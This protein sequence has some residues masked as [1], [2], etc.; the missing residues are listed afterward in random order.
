MSYQNILITPVGNAEDQASMAFNRAHRRTRE[1]IERAFGVIKSR[2]RCIDKS[3]GPLRFTPEKSTKVI[4]SVAL[5]HNKAI[6][7]EFARP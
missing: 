5:L 4:T 1:V 6:C 7:V 3:G 2:F